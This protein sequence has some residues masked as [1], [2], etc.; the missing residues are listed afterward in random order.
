MTKSKLQT[1]P[2]T[3]RRQRPSPAK[4]AP[5]G[6]KKNSSFRKRTADGMPRTSPKMQS[7][8]SAAKKMRSKKPMMKHTVMALRRDRAPLAKS[9]G[10]SAGKP[11][12]NRPKTSSVSNKRVM[13]RTKLIDASP[14]Q[15]GGRGTPV[16][17]LVKDAQGHA[18]AGTG[19]GSSHRKTVKSAETH[20]RRKVLN[21][22]RHRID[23]R[24]MTMPVSRAHEGVDFFYN[25]GRRVHPPAAAFPA[26][27]QMRL[28]G[29]AGYGHGYIGGMPG[30]NGGGGGGGGVI[31]GVGGYGVNLGG[32]GVNLGGAG[33]G[34]YGGGGASGLV[35]GNGGHGLASIAGGVATSG[36]GLSAKN[37]EVPLTNRLPIIDFISTNEFHNMYAPRKQRARSFVR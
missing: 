4:S 12:K 30:R 13:R 15:A 11:R 28:Q 22:A 31:G 8:P 9:M 21:Y 1:L 33:V 20:K 19:T 26:G 37:V 17:F 6:P 36:V 2:K 24:F 16:L 32:G 5:R 14:R 25:L 23:Q 3:D 35:M 7:M 27:R 18:I 34:N 10:K 29:G